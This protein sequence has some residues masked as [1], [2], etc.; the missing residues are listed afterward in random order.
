MNYSIGTDD[1]IAIAEKQYKESLQRNGLNDMSNSLNQSK[2][3]LSLAIPLS[4]LT[5]SMDENKEDNEDVN[6][7]GKKE[8]DDDS[9]ALSSDSDS[10]N[11]L[12]NNKKYDVQSSRKIVLRPSLYSSEPLYPIPEGNEEGMGSSTPSDTKNEEK[13][14]GN[15]QRDSQNN[16][17]SMNGQKETNYSTIISEDEDDSELPIDDGDIQQ[18]NG[19]NKVIEWEKRKEKRLSQKRFCIEDY[20]ENGND[21][22]KTKKKPLLILK[23]PSEDV[24]ND[25]TEPLRPKRLSFRILRTQKHGSGIQ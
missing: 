20:D 13:T 6:M 5:I 25:E 1:K 18:Y 3:S 8:D 12:L 15:S 9:F 14:K 11:D 7:S 23:N 22:K 2:D 24:I 17:T 21:I 19:L 16:D 10:Y 4:S